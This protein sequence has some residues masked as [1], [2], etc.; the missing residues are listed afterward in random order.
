MQSDRDDKRKA[1][2]AKHGLESKP[3]MKRRKSGHDY[4]GRCVYLITINVDRGHRLLGALQGADAEHADA[5]IKESELGL[6]VTEL[7]EAI[8]REQPLIRNIA[9]ALMPDHVHGILYV[10]GK[11]PRPL[12][13]YIARFKAKSTAE[14]RSGIASS[15]ATSSLWEAG[16]NDRVLRGGGELQRWID[17]LR[18]NPRRRWVKTRHPE[19]FTSHSGILLKERQV[20]VMGNRFLLSHPDK[21]AVRCSRSLSEEEI[22]RESGRFLAQAAEGAVLVSPCISRGEK[23]VMRR[24]FAAGYPQ[25]VLLENGFAPRQ[26]PTGRQFDAC[27]AGRLLLVA[28]WAHHNERR[29]ITRAQC[30]ALNRLAEEICDG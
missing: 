25:I 7:W 23:E 22:E 19:Y 30:E 24:A 28:P 6:R 27:A 3:S 1:W 21:I 8:A 12:G 9:F 18:D 14:W 26:K 20:A 10:T 15:S 17:Y 11:L 4:C 16:F 29:P 13:H 5:W 2:A